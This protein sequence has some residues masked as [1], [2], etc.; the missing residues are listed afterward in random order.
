MQELLCVTLRPEGNSQRVEALCMHGV[1]GVP[2]TGNTEKVG[3]F[4]TAS[5]LSVLAFT[6]PSEVLPFNSLG[7]MVRSHSFTAPQLITTRFY[8]LLMFTHLE[9]CKIGIL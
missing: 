5:S 7:V 9:L 2:D 4:E 3:D 1:R 6:L 8:T